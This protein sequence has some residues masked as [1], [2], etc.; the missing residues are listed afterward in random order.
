M[1]QSTYFPS[2]NL[3]GSSRANAKVLCLSLANAKMGEQ[4]LYKGWMMGK[5]TVISTMGQPTIQYGSA[6]VYY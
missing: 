5:L 3:L 4:L 6:F 2:I 1:I